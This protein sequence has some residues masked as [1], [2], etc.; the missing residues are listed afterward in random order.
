MECRPPK[1]IA[2][3]RSKASL[4]RPRPT[5]D[6]DGNKKERSVVCSAPKKIL[7]RRSARRKIRRCHEIG[8]IHAI[9]AHSRLLNSGKH[10]ERRTARKRRYIQQLPSGSQPFSQWLQ[11]VHSIERQILK[12]TQ[13]ENVLHVEG[14]RPLVRAWIERILRRALQNYPC[15]CRQ[16]AQ[17]RACVIQRFRKR[18]ASLKR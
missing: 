8:T 1:C 15:I 17:H 6:I 4:I 3:E 7:A 16:T 14:G 12:Q 2:P 5:G 10:G 9:R 11:K 13:R 18:V